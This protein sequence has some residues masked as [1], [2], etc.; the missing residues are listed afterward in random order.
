MMLLSWDSPVVKRLLADERIELA[1]FRH[2]DA[3]VA[4]FPY[5]SKVIAAGRCRRPRQEAAADDIVLVA[6]KASLIVQQGL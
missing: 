2:A 1:S 4:L 5:L 3:Y 6:P